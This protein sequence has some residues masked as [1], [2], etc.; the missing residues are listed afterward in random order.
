MHEQK[1]SLVIES[2]HPAYEWAKKQSDAVGAFGHI[3]TH[4]D[5]YDS[6][7]LEAQYEVDVVVINCTHEMPS[8][9]DLEPL[10]LADKALVLF[11]ANIEQN[12]YGTP[13][14]GV[15]NTALTSDA[16]EQILLN[17][18]AFIVID[19]YGIGSHGD[20]HIGFDKRC[21]S[22]GCFVIENVNLSAAVTHSMVKLKIAFDKDSKSTGKRCDISAICR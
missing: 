4:I 9:D 14:Y 11:T 21:E 2:G 7:P 15:M 3:G 16:I 18:P 8:V 17:A 19:S 20:E 6:E 10:A 13:N 5:C 1:L 22:K 12:G